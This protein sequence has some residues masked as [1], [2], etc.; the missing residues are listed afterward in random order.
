MAEE[1]GSVSGSLTKNFEAWKGLDSLGNIYYHQHMCW[2]PIP[3]VPL[4]EVSE[5]GQVR[6]RRLSAKYPTRGPVS[7]TINARGY[8][9]VT[10]AIN[11]KPKTFTVASLVAAA[12]LGPRPP[13]LTVNHKDGNKQNDHWTNLEYCTRLENVQHAWK[14]G[15]MPTTRSYLPF[16]VVE[17]IRAYAQAHPTSTYTDIGRV[18][19]ISYEVASKILRRA[20]YRDES[21][22]ARF[23]SRSARMRALYQAGR[24][25]PKHGV[26]HDRAALTQEQ[27]LWVLTQLQRGQSRRQ[28]AKTLGISHTTV[29]LYVRRA[30]KTPDYRKSR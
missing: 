26:E 29:N 11:A 20:T 27:V 19:G 10:V 6:H 7:G 2:K 21:A 14:M 3:H 30:N 24:I 16:T 13:G 17:Q 28:I 25:Q 8:R 18:F 5:T 23:A 4:Y 22:A 1:A 12:F 9:V 15:L